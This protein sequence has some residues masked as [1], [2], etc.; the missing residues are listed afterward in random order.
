V[1]TLWKRRPERMETDEWNR[2][3]DATLIR[4]NRAL[5]RLRRLKK[6]G[7][8]QCSKMTAGFAVVALFLLWAVLPYAAELY[9]ALL[10]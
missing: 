1:K 5:S 2:W 3:F 6:H 10:R 4:R 7:W 9:G 8:G